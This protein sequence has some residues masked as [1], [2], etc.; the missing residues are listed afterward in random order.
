MHV[1]TPRKK[2]WIFSSVSANYGGIFSHK[3]LRLSVVVDEY[4]I[5]LLSVQLSSPQIHPH[6]L[7]SKFDTAQTSSA[8]FQ[9]HLIRYASENRPTRLEDRR[10]VPISPHLL[11][12]FQVRPGYQGAR[13]FLA[14]GLRRLVYSLADSFLSLLGSRVRIH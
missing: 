11:G 9:F 4:N 3:P 14:K 13:S 2:Q 10:T 8:P 5:K 6:D 12:Q 1:V 7:L